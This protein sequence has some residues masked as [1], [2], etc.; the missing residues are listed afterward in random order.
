MEK[1]TRDD[2]AVFVDFENVYVS[3][4]EKFDATPNFE[5]IMDR[6]EDYGRIVIARAYADWYRYP[7][8]TSA[9]FA[10]GVEPMYVPTYYYDRDVGRTGRPIKNSVDIHLCIDAMRTLYSQPNILKFV[11]VTGDRDFIP[12][13]NAIRQHGKDVIVIGIG[14]AASAHLAQSADEFLFYE[15]IADLATR[16]PARQIE[17]AR[18]PEERRER[19]DRP[20]RSRAER[21]P[22]PEA[23]PEP[24]P[25][26]A[27]PVP[28]AAPA[29]ELN[30]Y[31]TL[32]DAVKLARQRGFV[33]NLGSLKVVMR[34][35]DSTFHESKA[36]DSAGRGFSKFKD[37][38]K[39]AERQGKVQIF[40]NGTVTEIF[41]PEEDPYTL[42]QFAEDLASQRAERELETELEQEAQLAEAV[43]VPD[44][45]QAAPEAAIE[46]I[47][48]EAAPETDEEAVTAE[49]EA[50][51]ASR[52]S[53]GDREW[54]IFRG[55]MS[56]FG[57]PVRFAEI[58]NALRGLRNQEVMELTNNELK[59]LVKQAINRG[60]LQRTG[61]GA[62]AYYRLSSQYRVPRTEAAD[63]PAVEPVATPAVE[64][65]DLANAAAAVAEQ[66]A[67]VAVEVRRRARRY[68]RVVAPAEPAPVA[69]AAEA[70]APAA[71]EA[72]QAVPAGDEAAVETPP[73]IQAAAPAEVTQVPAEAAPARRRRRKSSTSAGNG[74][75]GATVDNNGRAEAETKAAAPESSTKRRRKKAAPAEAPE[76]EQ[77]PVP[78]AR[79]NGTKT[80]RRRK[81]AASNG[82]GDTSQG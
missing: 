74:Q 58:F 72:A 61:R 54:D 73:E 81:K 14:G 78:E 33:V 53:F 7:R 46:T 35:L 34:E 9:L 24:A 42:S 71:V 75:N 8:V 38:V 49:A 59:E 67:A 41:L 44:V 11:L 63:T 10:N 77:A 37:F 51:G 17:E 13:V 70:Q 82:D 12:L 52:A 50:A 48:P 5:L 28:E 22:K 43:L 47:Q 55:S 25:Q 27:V 80:R 32:V 16:Q 57:E 36:K 79:E 6:C 2:V 18:R 3:V 62:R 23:R 76:P 56:Q 29:A 1:A 65:M 45:Q 40:T 64:A 19:S 69:E 26:E 60:M 30:P 15:Q 39:E 21:S 66:A 20:E 68:D 31:D 4:R